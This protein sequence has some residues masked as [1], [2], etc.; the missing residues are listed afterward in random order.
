M[1]ND[2]C[3]PTLHHL[4]E[5]GLNL[6]LGHRVERACGLIQDQNRRV[7]EKRARDREALTLAAGKHP[8]ALADHHVKAFRIA[9]HDVHNLRALT[10]RYH[11][12]FGRIGFSD[13]EIFGDGSV[14]Q[15]H[16][17]EN[18]ADVAP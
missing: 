12:C 11:F 2:E 1:G 16:L 10:G 18:N 8:S 14:E 4:V 5:R 17:L 6:G 15:K 7:F 13:Q 3:G 9:P